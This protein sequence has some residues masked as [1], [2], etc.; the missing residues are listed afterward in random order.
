MWDRMFSE[1]A[2]QLAEMRLPASRNALL[3]LRSTLVSGGT[4]SELADTKVGFLCRVLRFETEGRKFLQVEDE[5]LYQKGS[6]LFG[7]EVETKFATAGA[8]EID[9]AGKCL[10]VGRS[11]ACVFHLMRVMELGVKAT[12]SCLGIPDP[13][14]DSERNWGAMLRKTKD[15][16]DRRNKANPLLWPHMDDKDFFAEIYVSLDAVRNVWRNATMH[17]ENKYTPEEAQHIMSAVRGFM[18]KLA[19]RCDERGLPLA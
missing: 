7:S 3:D 5:D 8:F 18:R 15:E 1:Y 17:V 14:K 9:E 16:I 11:T 13:V 19:S 4:Y 12:G 10:A 6:Q 2:E